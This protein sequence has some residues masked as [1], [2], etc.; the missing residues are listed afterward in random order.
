MNFKQFKGQRN[1]RNI[2]SDTVW[3][4]SENLNCE[5]LY[6][7]K[8]PHK[9]IY[10]YIFKNNIKIHKIIEMKRALR[11]K[12][13]A[14]QLLYIYIY[15]YWFKQ[16]EKIKG[17]KEGKIKWNKEINIKYNLGKVNTIWISDDSKDNVYIILIFIF[18]C[19]NDIIVL[20]EQRGLIFKIYTTKYLEIECD[21]WDCLKNNSGRVS[22]VWMKQDWP[23]I[24]NGWIQMNWKR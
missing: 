18:S 17:K 23:G 12:R 14:N 13:H 7:T 2:L 22:R 15:I 9:Y 3:R 6:R 10:I 4:Q 5:K 16:N 20:L 1:I 19:N 24:E 8:K 11:D 21:F